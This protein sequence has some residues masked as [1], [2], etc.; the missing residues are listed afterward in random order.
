MLAIIQSK[1]FCPS[2]LYQKTY[3]QK[4]KNSNFAVVL[5]GC[6]TWFLTL[7]EEYRLT[8]FGNRVLRKIFGPI[9]EEDGS[10]RKLHND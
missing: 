2:V 8:V 1:I 4:Y 7:G 9:N 5:Y 10:W 6:E 3:R